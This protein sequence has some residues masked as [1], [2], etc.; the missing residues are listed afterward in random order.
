MGAAM[1][2]ILILI[3][4][5]LLAAP[6]LLALLR[7]DLGWRTGG[8]YG[9][10]VAALLAWHVGFAIGPIPSAASLARA[11]GVVLEGSRCEQALQTATQARMIVDRRDPRRLVVNRELWQQMPESVREALTECARTTRPLGQREEPLEV[12]N[13]AG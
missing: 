7:Q 3:L 13:A 9:A 2:T 5:L 11:P 8:F 4:F 1:S 10:V 12:V 6:A